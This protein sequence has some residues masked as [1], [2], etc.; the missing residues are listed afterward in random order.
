MRGRMQEGSGHPNQVTAAD[1]GSELAAAAVGAAATAAAAPADAGP[2]P[3]PP[4][5]GHRR[6][7]APADRLFADGDCEREAQATQHCNWEVRRHLQAGGS[8]D[9]GRLRLVTQW[10]LSPA[11]PVSLVHACQ[12]T[13][14]VSQPLCTSLTR[15][16]PSVQHADAK[17]LPAQ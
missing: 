5:E 15:R 14:T 3:L 8:E 17:V 16:A 13:L 7:L 10:V 2:L 9:G 11:E 6:R 12:A 4:F 1:V